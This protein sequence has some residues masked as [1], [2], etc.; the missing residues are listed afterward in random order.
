MNVPQMTRICALA[1]LTAPAVMFAQD[2]YLKEAGLPPTFHCGDREDLQMTHKDRLCYWWT[3]SFN[4]QMIFGA[5]FNSALD[6]IF[7]NST[8]KYWGQGADG[9]FRRFGTRVAQ[10]FVKGSG[11]ALVGAI[12][13]EDPRFYESRKTGFGPRFWFALEHTLVVKVDCGE[14][15][16][17]CKKERFSV[18]RV[19][20]AFSSGFV[21]MLWTPDP[22]N[23]PGDA[24]VRSGTAMSG[25]LASSLWKEFQPD[26][27]RLVSKLF[28]RAPQPAL[29][30]RNKK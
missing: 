30:N 1:W 7:N 25:Y 9:Y 26:V 10:S 19:G 17:D 16:E 24:L 14:G 3:N 28:K 6:P 23:K 27:M 5:A 13:H 4:A 20:G 18:G 29:P 2:E 22:I 8:N 21:G 15:I 12:A 11:Q